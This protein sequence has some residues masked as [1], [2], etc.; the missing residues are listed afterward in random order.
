MISR[1]IYDMCKMMDTYKFYKLERFDVSY[2]EIINNLLSQ[3]SSSGKNITEAMLNEI[4]S[5]DS[6]ELYLMLDDTKVIGMFTLGFYV[7]PTGRKCW[8]E[9]VVIDSRYRGM[10]LGK[11]LM[12]KVMEIVSEKGN[13]TLMLTSKPSRIAANRLYQSSGMEKKET[14]VYIKCFD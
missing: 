11:T 14:N 12:Q 5:S 4:I 2:I 9:D 1:N 7:S 10:S 3:L 6:S 13:T 8:L